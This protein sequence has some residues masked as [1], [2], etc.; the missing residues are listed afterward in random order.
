MSYLVIGCGYIGE[1]VADL[2]HEAGH[3][4][5]GVTHSQESAQKL[6]SAKAYPVHACDVS[7]ASEVQA[8]AEK[9]EVSPAWVIHCASSSRGGAE[10]YRQVHLGGCSNLGTSFPEAK[11]LFTSSTSVY[12]QTDGSVVTEESDATPDRETSQ[13]LRAT[14]DLVLAGGGT[15]A[16]LAGIYGPARSFVLKSYLE[17]TATIE[18]NEGNGRYLNQIHREDAARA[19]VHLATSAPAGIYN[20]TDDTPVTQREC[21]TALSWRFQKLMPPVTEP[22][23]QRKR[24]WTHKQVSNAKLRSTGFTLTFPSYEQAIAEDPELVRS[25]MAQLAVN[26]SPQPAGEAACGCN[27]ILV[28]LMGSGKSTVGRMVAH[29]LGFG[30]ADTDHLITDAAGQTIPEIFAAEGE[31]G[32]RVRETAALRSLVGRDGMVIATGGGIVTRPENLP[33]LKQLGFVVWLNA[34]PNTLHRRTAHSHDRPLLKNPDPA[35]TLRKLHEGR[36]PL[37]E[38][39]S[40]MK[41]NTDDFSPQD[42]AYGVAETARVHFSK[43]SPAPRTHPH[44]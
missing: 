3:A 16:R 39:A 29:S 43:A 9:L 34:D 44:S 30:F 33:L 26:G 23:N 24:A 2:L 38:Q 15:V 40:D 41:I 42:V 11:I 1:R 4:V 5:V 7:Q 31:E 12:P 10:T 36:S 32:F 20:V 6:A 18:G 27:V 17:G 21:F 25:I 13:I 14:E 28:G 37:Y 35:G 22:N 19:L 8:L